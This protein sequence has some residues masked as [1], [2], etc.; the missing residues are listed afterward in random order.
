MSLQR[1]RLGSNLSWWGLGM[2]NSRAASNSR[3]GWGNCKRMVGL[4]KPV[5]FILNLRRQQSQNVGFEA[6]TAMTVLSLCG[7]GFRGSLSVALGTAR[8]SLKSCRLGE[9]SGTAIPELGHLDVGCVSFRLLG[10][11]PI[12][13]E[14]IKRI[15][16]V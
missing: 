2:P 9:Y 6:R 10:Q 11:C 1:C 12:E 5:C 3:I 14:T 7:E 4:N 8:G 13:L 16:H 15:L